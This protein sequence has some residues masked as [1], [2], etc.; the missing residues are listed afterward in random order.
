MSTEPA[1]KEISRQKL[2]QLDSKIPKEWRLPAKWIPAGMHSPEESVANTK[3]DAINV[4]DIPRQCGLLSTKQLEI[5][6]KWDV[7]GLLGEMASGRL[8]VTEVCEAFCKRAA[9]AHQL[10]RCLTEPLFDSALKR[11]SFLDAHLKRTGKPYGPLHGLVV[12]VKDTFDVEGVDS[13]TGLA[14]LAFKPAK[15][16]APLVDLLYSLGAVIITKTN[17]PQTLAALDSVNN[18]F[19]RTLNPLNRQLTAGGSSGGEGALVAMRGSMI[20]MGTDIGGSIRI[21]AMC[22]GIYG[23]KPSNGRVPFGGQESAMVL[24]RGRTS[25]QAVAGPI[26]RSMSDINVVM[27]EIVPRSELWGVDCIPGKWASETPALGEGEPRKFTI[28]ILRS[29]GRIPPLPPIAKLLDEVAQKLAGVQGVE[30]VEIPVPK[31]LGD[32]QSLANALM[33]VDGGGFMVDLIENTG[34]SLIPWLQGKTKRGKPK[35]LAQVFDLQAKREE[36]E[37]AMM[38]MWTR[39]ADQTRKVDAIIH[40][41]APHPVPELDRYNAVGYTSSWVLLDYPA[42]TIPVRNFNEADLDLGKEMDSKI[43]TSWDKRNRELWNS[44]TVNRRV[45]LNSPLSIQV[46]TPKLHDYDLYHAMDL[47][48]K[49][50]NGSKSSPVKL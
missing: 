36:I 42:G 12:S 21:P 22:N 30:V 25:I 15:K 27:K 46:L 20:G 38:E 28:G 35:T 47:I 29:D 6:E 43:L 4:M 41:V 44:N 5:T 16:N 3:Y 8:T 33:A 1:F 10:T 11:A 2:A 17:I 40:P 18:L 26:A 50:L 32:C 45:Y 48:D 24:G 39:G 31:A 34:E 13:T 9:I 49:A 7:K 19:G 14:S 37:K 23:F